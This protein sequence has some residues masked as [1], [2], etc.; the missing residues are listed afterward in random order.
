MMTI[1]NENASDINHQESALTKENQK[2]IRK[3]ERYINTF[4]L[5]TYDIEQIKRDL[6]GM[7]LEAQERGESFI[8]VLGKKPR[9]FC[10]DFIY[11]VCGLKAPGGRK[12]LRFAAA[13][14]QIFGVFSLVMALW[15]LPLAWKE[16]SYGSDLL[17]CLFYGIFYYAA[18]TKALRYSNDASKANLALKWGVIT[19]LVENTEHLFSALYSSIGDPKP[20]LL[21]HP[22]IHMFDIISCIIPPVIYIIGAL[23]NRPCEEES[24]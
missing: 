19:L 9:A 15:G 24:I 3:M 11:T 4:P 23:K 1:I 8:S 12:L 2:I 16:W 22:I 6:T 21:G 17:T 5:E 7:A 14:Y 10:D 13:Y 18:G 20:A